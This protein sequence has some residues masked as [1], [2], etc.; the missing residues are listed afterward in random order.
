MMDTKKLDGL[1]NEQ[2]AIFFYRKF[3]FFCSPNFNAL[4]LDGNIFEWILVNI[5]L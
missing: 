2:D 3:H 1:M 4:A 5:K